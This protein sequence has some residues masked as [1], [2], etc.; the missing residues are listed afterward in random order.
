[1]P[2]RPAITREQF[3]ATSE[4]A[5]KSAYWALAGCAVWLLGGLAVFYWTVPAELRNEP[6]FNDSRS[7]LPF[8]A[9]IISTLVLIFWSLNAVHR[10]QG[11]FCPA[12]DKGLTGNQI[13]IAT[14][15]CAYCGTSLFQNDPPL[16]LTTP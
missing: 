15:N 3:I 8:A 6:V 12:C 5:H 10:R 16:G 4:R 13:V 7:G 1:M 9:I 14:G 2:S 11:I